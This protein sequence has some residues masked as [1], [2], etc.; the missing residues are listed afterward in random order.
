MAKETV[1]LGVAN[2]G[3]TNLDVDVVKT[4]IPKNINH[5]SDV[6]FFKHEKIYYSMKRVDFKKIFNL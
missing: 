4:W 3:E 5:F 6:V 1:K 2:A